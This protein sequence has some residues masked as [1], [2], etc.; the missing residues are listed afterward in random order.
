MKIDSRS[1][2]IPRPGRSPGL[3]P[4]YLHGDAPRP[5][6]THARGWGL[7]AARDGWRVAGGGG[8]G[9]GERR[10]AGALWEQNQDISGIL[11][12]CGWI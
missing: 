2:L 11:P 9:G 8:L 10:V 6:S 12:E 4:I 7:E 3:G 1:S 5:S